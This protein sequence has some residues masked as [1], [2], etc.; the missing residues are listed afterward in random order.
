MR[1]WIIRHCQ[2]SCRG[3]VMAHMAVS[4]SSCPRDVYFVMIWGCERHFQFSDHHAL[5]H[6]CS[7]PTSTQTSQ[8]S[9]LL[10]FLCWRPRAGYCSLRIIMAFTSCPYLCTGI[11]RTLLKLHG[12]PGAV[13]IHQHLDLSPPP[14]HDLRWWAELIKAW[15]DR[16]W[17]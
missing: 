5:A 7:K 14:F 16:S 8:T 11:S 12:F 17:W 1:H 10:D 9:E 4:H 13:L 6:P 15:A 3:L 2:N